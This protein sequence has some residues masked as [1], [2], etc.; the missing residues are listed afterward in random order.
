MIG[1]YLDALERELARLGEP[2]EVDT[3]FF[4]G[5]TPTHLPPNSLAQ[6][7][8]IVDRWFPRAAA[9]E[10]SVEANPEDLDDARTD[11]LAAAG[12][13]RVSLGAQSF[14]G[15]KLALL[16]RS[17]DSTAIEAAVIRCRRFADSISVDLIFGTP[18]ETL[19]GW[20]HDLEAALSL[21]PEHVSTYGLTY[22]RGTAYWGRLMRNDLARLDEE[23][24]RE[25]Y[26]AAID[27]LTAAGLQ[28]Y[29]VSN[30][31]R[32]GHRCRHNEAY[33][34]GWSYHAAGPG[35]ARFVNGR[36]EMNHRS[37]TT[38]IRR[39]LAG[40][41]PVA[42][43]ESLPPEDAARERLVFGLRRI[44][45]VCL[46]RFAMETGFDIERLCG[47]I[48]EKYVDLGMLETVDGTLRLTREGLLV[49]D[50]LWPD[51]LT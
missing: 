41:S 42:E 4:G 34:L 47:S 18:D 6:M 48:V 9:C 19:P 20:R 26:L 8:A 43:S 22:E 12:V 2:C 33:W 29:E 13:T 10:V 7:F 23:L 32:T 28:H 39:V 27:A 50:S 3:L 15:R 45:G 25:M 30:F 5:G 46:Q 31:A 44:E 21:L 51:F 14:D 38:W 36:R 49:S 11:A 35:A 17:H 16:E 37:T 24:E 40:E 1:A